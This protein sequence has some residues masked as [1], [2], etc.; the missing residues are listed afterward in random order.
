MEVDANSQ[1]QF[2]PRDRRPDALGGFHVLPD[3]IVCSILTL[4]SPRDVA[5]L[6]CASR[7]LNFS[8]FVFFQIRNSGVYYVYRSKRRLLIWDISEDDHTYGL[9]YN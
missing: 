9:D 2:V 6:A 7:L 5:R 8:Y 3:E 4:L 1:A